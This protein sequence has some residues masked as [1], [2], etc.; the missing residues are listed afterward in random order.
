[1][2]LGYVFLWAVLQVTQQGLQV[3]PWD[4]FRRCLCVY[5]FLFIQL[6]APTVRQSMVVPDIDG[7]ALVTRRVYVALTV[8]VFDAVAVTTTVYIP[9]LTPVSILPV[10]VPEVSRVSP[11][12]RPVDP[13]VA[14]VVSTN[15]YVDIE[16]LP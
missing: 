2:I 7:A 1:M 12:G 11:L 6:P 8:V 16:K 5:V 3:T 14:P 13:D 9:W 15:T 10:I 4:V